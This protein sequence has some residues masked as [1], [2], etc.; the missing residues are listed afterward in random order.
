MFKLELHI[1]LHLVLLR[2]GCVLMGM[3]QTDILAGVVEEFRELFHLV[4]DAGKP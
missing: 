3:K 1:D 4:A 2:D